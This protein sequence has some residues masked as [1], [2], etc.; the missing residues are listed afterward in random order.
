[1]G[2]RSLIHFKED[3]KTF[4]TV[5][6]QFDG[7]PSGRGLE[8]AEWLSNITVVNGLTGDGKHVANGLGCLAAQWIA[9]EKDGPGGIYMVPPGK[10]PDLEEYTYDVDVNFD[11][12]QVT[13]R[14]FDG[15]E[16]VFEGP[17]KGFAKF[18]NQQEA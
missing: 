11:T 10:E 17:A 16:K 18:L 8:L 9:H 15:D 13:L 4:C 5:Y 14:C 6:R 12:R 3:G 2:T 7:Y 1:M